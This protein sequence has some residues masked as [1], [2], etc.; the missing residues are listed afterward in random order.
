MLRRLPLFEMAS[1]EKVLGIRRDL[2]VPLLE[3]RHAVANF[4]WEVRSA[5]WQKGF[6]EEAEALFRKKVEPEVEKIKYAVKENFSY[7]ELGHRA[8]RHGGAGLAGGVVEGFLASAS[9]LTDVSSA[10]LLGGVGCPLIQAL[11][12]K[13]RRLEEIED[14]QLYFY[15]AAEEALSGGRRA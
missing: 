10:A 4:A 5:A 14:N 6:A 11:L 9:S 13:H 7:A 1:I 15:Y 8:L 2:R 3:F 12:D